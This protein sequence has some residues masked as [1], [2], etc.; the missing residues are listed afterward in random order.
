MAAVRQCPMPSFSAIQAQVILV[1]RRSFAAM[2][3]FTLCPFRFLFNSRFVGI[4]LVYAL[5]QW[6][7]L[8]VY[9]DDGRV[10][11]DNNLVENAI[12]PTALGKRNWLFIGDADAGTRGA[13]IYTIIESCRRRH[14]RNR[15]DGS[16][17]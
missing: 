4:A 14:A 7:T 6:R 15:P 13:I 10:E 1:S 5:G 9:L 11:I 17:K 2:P 8:D 16:A 12:R 3:A